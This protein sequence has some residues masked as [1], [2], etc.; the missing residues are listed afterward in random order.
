MAAI[1]FSILKEVTIYSQDRSESVDLIPGVVSFNY[2]E[3]LYSPTITA[4][5]VVV[6]TSQSYIRGKRQ[7]VYNGLPIRVGCYV[8]IKIAG[9]SGSNP[10]IEFSEKETALYV[11]GISNVISENQ[12]EAFTLHL[13]SK[14]A[15]TSETTK[16][17]EKYP[18]GP[19]SEIAKSII[20]KH[21]QPNV[22]VVIDPT[23]SVYGLECNSRKPFTLLVM[24]APRAV[25]DNKYAGAFFYQTRDGY[26]F[27]SVDK[28][29]AQQPKNIDSPYIYTE[30]NKHST[31]R[32][33]EFRILSY[34]VN[35]NENFLEKLRLGGYSSNISTFNYLTGEFKVNDVFDRR[36]YEIKNLGM[37]IQEQTYPSVFSPKENMM[38]V[39]KVSRSMT[40]IISH[41]VLDKGVGRTQDSDP[42]KD[43]RQSIIRYNTLVN[44]ELQ[45]TIPLNSTLR[46]GDIISCLFPKSTGES[47]KE[48]DREMSGLYMIKQLCH[49]F[50]SSYSITS[51]IIV[52][53]TFGLNGTNNKN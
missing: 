17:Y 34:S 4:K 9:N 23:T 41:G 25:F 27:R 52:R 21:L 18:V 2:Y 37:P 43:M 44:Q 15:L 45:M 32:N 1:D 51:L 36:K 16:V 40:Q 20:D 10:D 28:L 24:L 48:Y 49:H 42:T 7:S 39:D 8:S 11:S 53:D 33:N 13:V 14:E 12:R 50:D 3:D 26:F 47:T 5:L 29:I 46:A 30:V 38:I 22:P 35:K 31:V 6:S 19:V